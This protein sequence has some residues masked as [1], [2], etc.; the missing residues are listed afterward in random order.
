MTEAPGDK[1][2]PMTKRQLIDEII[3]INRTAQPGFLARFEES[4]LDEYLRHLV[5]ARTNRLSGDSSRFHK[6]FRSQGRAEGPK[7][8]MKIE[9][10]AP[11]EIAPIVA[12]PEPTPV[13]ADAPVV[14]A[15]APVAEQPP[16]PV[17]LPAP[18]PAVWD[19][20]GEADAATSVR[21]EQEIDAEFQ[22]EPQPQAEHDVAEDIEE[23]AAVDCDAELADDPQEAIHEPAEENA[24]SR[25]P[26]MAGV[27][28][29]SDQSSPP[30]A[31]DDKK[32]LF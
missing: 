19:E 23:A 3:T 10:P 18:V 5:H 7:T 20:T 2:R 13:P 31:K 15:P 27:A 14:A 1:D 32:W 26:V 12:A 17:E 28:K 6:Y 25:E 22:S 11:V 30:F 29:D 21:V 24:N 16:T 4:D 9:A 8:P